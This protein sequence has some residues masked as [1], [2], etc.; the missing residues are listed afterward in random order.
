[1]WAWDS[2]FS[3]CSILALSGEKTGAFGVFRKAS[4]IFPGPLGDMAGLDGVGRV[5]A[6][7][8]PDV[9]VTTV[10]LVCVASVYNNS[11]FTTTSLFPEMQGTVLE[12]IM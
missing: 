11:L 3:V 4:L 2:A 12:V 5:C 1:V 7:D 9:T 10:S 8:D 6:G